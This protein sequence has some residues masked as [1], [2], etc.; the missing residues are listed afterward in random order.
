MGGAVAAPAPSAGME[1]L[2]QHATGQV[3]SFFA[4]RG[5]GFI[6]MTPPASG[7]IF[8]AKRDLPIAIQETNLIGVKIEFDIGSSNDGRTQAKNLLCMDG[9]SSSFGMVGPKGS[10][11]G[12]ASDGSRLLGQIRDVNQ[13]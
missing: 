1:M 12:D 4:K 9:D 10:G 2:G 6:S 13:V 3:K 7:D 5:Y 8:F 11:K